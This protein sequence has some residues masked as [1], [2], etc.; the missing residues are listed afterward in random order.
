MWALSC[1]CRELSII[2]CRV[3]VG[4]LWR[5]RR[6]ALPPFVPT[7]SVE[8]KGRFRG[9]YRRSRSTSRRDG[10]T[11]ASWASKRRW[12]W[13]PL[14]SCVAWRPG[15]RVI[16][17]W[18]CTWCALSS[19]PRL[20]GATIQQDRLRISSLLRYVIGLLSLIL[21]KKFVLAF[22]KWGELPINLTIISLYLYLHV[23]FYRLYESLNWIIVLYCTVHVLYNSI[24]ELR[25][26]YRKVW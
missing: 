8:R 2:Q 3:A 12:R 1:S 16:P 20:A 11:T 15:R 9:A 14:P 17:K 4:S 25:I 7:S 10:W 23:I 13:H 24:G 18:G 19:I 21:R 6:N 5:S 26:P 22:N